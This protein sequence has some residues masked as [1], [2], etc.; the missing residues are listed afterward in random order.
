MNFR[1]SLSS[2]KTMV[3]PQ[4][5]PVSNSDAL[6]DKILSD[7]KLPSAPSVALRIVELVSDPECEIDKVIQLLSTDAAICAQLLK[8][9]NSSL[10]ALSRPVTSVKRAVA[11]LG[12][13]PLRSIV[14]GLALPALQTRVKKDD[15]L[16]RFW[17][18]SVAAAIIARELAITQRDPLYEEAFIA[19]LLCDLG[20]VILYQT[21]PKSYEPAWSGRERVFGEALCAWEMRHLGIEH[22]T[23][24]AGLLKRWRLP[25]EIVEPV[26]Y[27]HCVD[28]AEDQPPH[29]RQRTALLSFSHQVASI[30][31]VKP[32]DVLP[33]LIEEAG[34]TFGMNKQEFM[35]FLKDVRPKIEAF[36]ELLQVDIGQC[37][38]YAEVV[39]LGCNEL[40]RLSLEIEKPP[41]M[42]GAKT[43]P[44][45]RPN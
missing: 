22:P 41:S 11:I 8:T 34:T 24:S 31:E 13:H 29:I 25:P 30:D 2:Q 9:L 26:R 3:P 21:I 23:V 32:K 15:G 44:D 36:A 43:K 33:G 35:N 20:T 19:C 10:Y 7:P 37:P 6:L 4:S 39:S 45:Q 38:N 12:L 40:L 1:L 28:D 42:S 14:L 17:R 27:H 16:R 18:S 5:R